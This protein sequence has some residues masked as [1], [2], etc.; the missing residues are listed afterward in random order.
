MAKRTPSFISIGQCTCM[1]KW[2]PKSAHPKWDR[3][4]P[5]MLHAPKSQF[6][7]LSKP[8]LT[9]ATSA[10]FPRGNRFSSKRNITLGCGASAAASLIVPLVWADCDGGDMMTGRRRLSQS[11][12]SV[13]IIFG[14]VNHSK[15]FIRKSHDRTHAEPCILHPDALLSLTW[16][17]THQPSPVSLWV[18]NDLSGSNGGRGRPI[19]IPQRVP[20]I[21]LPSLVVIL[22]LFS[23][24]AIRPSHHSHFLLS[25]HF[26]SVLS[27]A[28][29][30]A[31]LFRIGFRL[32]RV[33]PVL[34]YENLLGIRRKVSN[35]KPT[36][37]HEN[38]QCSLKCSNII[39]F[40]DT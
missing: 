23:G 15:L 18:A 16:A 37:E 27:F 30:R 13:A 31:C 5:G 34:Q 19:L 25:C 12:G 11:V 39:Y 17:H 40:I 4:G 33:D 2:Q 14:Q 32:Y 1:G 24:L 21:H 26:Y 9:L 7:D 3:W 10:I 22:Y 35:S 20:S 38:L 6:I 29:A 8:T 28:L 36:F